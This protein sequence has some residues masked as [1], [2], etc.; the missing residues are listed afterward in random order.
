MLEADLASSVEGLPVTCTGLWVCSKVVDGG[1][2]MLA[3]GAAASG[4]AARA[5]AAFRILPVS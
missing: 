2:T 5:R 1:A 3:L 4:V